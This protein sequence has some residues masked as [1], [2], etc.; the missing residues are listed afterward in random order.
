MITYSAAKLKIALAI[1]RTIEALD[2]KVRKQTAKLNKI[3]GHDE[4]PGASIKG[5]NKVIPA[6]SFDVT[7]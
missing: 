1:Q 6:S 2:A 4:A 5:K 3:L 7:N